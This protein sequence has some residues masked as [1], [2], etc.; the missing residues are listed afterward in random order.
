MGG[1]NAA[2]VIFDL[3]GVLI[4]SRSAVSDCM[5]HALAAQGMPTRPWVDLYRYVGPPLAVAFAEIL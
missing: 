5:N 4:D 3:D 2:T 1:D